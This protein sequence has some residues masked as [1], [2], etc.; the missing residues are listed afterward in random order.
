MYFVTYNSGIM[1]DSIRNGRK[2]MQKQAN[3]HQILGTGL[4]I[5]MA[6]F[7]FGCP[8]QGKSDSPPL[9]AGSSSI[10]ITPDPKAHDIPLGGYGDRNGKPATGVHD[11]VMSRA[12]YLEQGDTKVALVSCDL[13]YIPFSLADAVRSRLQEGGK[14]DVFLFMAATHSHSAPE[15]MAM[16]SN[17]TAGNAAIGMY[18]PWLLDWTANIVALSVFQAMADAKPVRIAL[19]TLE[20]EGLIRNRRD[21]ATVDNRLTVLSISAGEEQ[22]VAMI[23]HF[24][25]HP[26]ILGADMMEISADWPGAL[27]RTL[28]KNIGAGITVLYLNGAQGDVTTVRPEGSSDIEKMTTFGKRVSEKVLECL[29]SSILMENPILKATELPVKLPPKSLFPQFAAIAGEEYKMDEKQALAFVEQAFPNKV[30]I[31]ALRIGSLVMVG[32]PGEM[33]SAL[34]M[35]I[36]TELESSGKVTALVVGLVNDVVGYILPP[37]EYDQGGY[38]A[39]ASFYGRTLGTLMTESAIKAGKSVLE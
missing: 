39:T 33:T 9:L 10:S 27:C 38:E 37:E 32:I 13:L 1:P 22:P 4:L 21:D 28:E 30:T 8:V 29:D 2:K 34:G 35:K 11:P 23:V 6:V 14:E 31:S 25:A 36:R 19:G 3:L 20:T 16:N 7:L 24:A 26:T 17:N 18:D 12:V 5:A 15:A